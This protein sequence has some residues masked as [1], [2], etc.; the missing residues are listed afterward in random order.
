MMRQWINPRTAAPHRMD[1]KISLV[2]VI[3]LLFFIFQVSGAQRN[4]T[5]DQTESE[6]TTVAN[7]TNMSTAQSHVAHSVTTTKPQTNPMS[8]AAYTMTSTTEKTKRG[9]YRIVV[10]EP[11]WDEGFTYDYERLRLIGLPIA[12]GLFLIGIMIIGCGRFCRL[13]RCCKRS[14]KSYHVVRG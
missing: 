3:S 6:S 12:S 2:S 10:W 13:C 9:T 14:S 8:S 4:T 1:N 7:T 11:K 5:T